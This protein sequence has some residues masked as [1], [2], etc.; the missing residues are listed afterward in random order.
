M[1]ARSRIERLAEI[2]AA[3]W[4]AYYE[5]EQRA[6]RERLAA[7]ANTTAG[8]TLLSAREVKAPQ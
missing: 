3:A 7:G 6:L 5:A 8:S 2:R 1:I 4:I